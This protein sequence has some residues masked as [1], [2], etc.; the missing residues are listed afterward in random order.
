MFFLNKSP[1]SR[2]WSVKAKMTMTTKPTEKEYFKSSDLAL[3]AV[4]FLFF[5]LEG[6][7]KENPRKALFLFE[8]DSDGHL[9]E[10]ITDYWRGELKVDPRRYFEAL[11]QIKA[12]LY[13]N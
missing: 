5:P 1:T 12:R 9:D 3:A 11:R 4:L 13:E 7:D 8:K 10:T 2:H 6:I